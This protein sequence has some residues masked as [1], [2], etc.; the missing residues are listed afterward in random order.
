MAML[1]NKI[2]CPFC[3]RYLNK[4]K[5]SSHTANNFYRKSP[6]PPTAIQQVIRHIHIYT[7]CKK[8]GYIF[9]FDSIP[10]KYFHNKRIR[11]RKKIQ[12][13]IIENELERLLQNV[14]KSHIHY[15]PIYPRAQDL[16]DT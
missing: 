10:L 4:I 9:A 15:K 5:I 14:P 11:K 13:F 16:L 8:C 6:P 3:H 12:D 7:D 1:K 2:R